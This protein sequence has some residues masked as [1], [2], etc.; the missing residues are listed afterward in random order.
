[1]ACADSRVVLMGQASAHV[2]QQVRTYRVALCATGRLALH[3][4]CGSNDGGWTSFGELP[5]GMEAS[6]VTQILVSAAPMS[7]YAQVVITLLFDDGHAITTTLCDSRKCGSWR[8]VSEI[9][10]ETLAP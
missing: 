8:P 1:M 2:H 3:E 4:T 9:N 5:D 10:W 6:A 7:Y